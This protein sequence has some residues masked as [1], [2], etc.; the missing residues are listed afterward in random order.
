MA[1]AIRPSVPGAP[2]PQALSPRQPSLYPPNT[3]ESENTPVFG[4]FKIL[5]E[6]SCRPF[7]NPLQ[8]RGLPKRL[9]FGNRHRKRPARELAAKSAPAPVTPPTAKGE[10]SH[11][12]PRSS[13][14]RYFCFSAASHSA[15]NPLIRPSSRSIALR[16]SPSQT[17]RSASSRRNIVRSQPRDSVSCISSGGPT[18]E[19]M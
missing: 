5:C 16:A 14:R 18:T 15:F 3:I 11:P 8:T 7:Q 4:P 10:R 12:C 2:L 19:S 17:S 1:P 9:F 13:K 6:N